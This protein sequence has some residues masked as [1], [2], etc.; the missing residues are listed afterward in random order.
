MGVDNPAEIRGV[1]TTGT[2][3][4]FAS[5]SPQ[6]PARWKENPLELKNIALT[7]AIKWKIRMFFLWVSFYRP[8]CFV[9]TYSGVST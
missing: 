7:T 2:H 8:N 5:L 6:N 4:N 1:E 3:N 9:F